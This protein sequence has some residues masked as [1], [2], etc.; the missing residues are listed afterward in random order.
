M[1]TSL[2]TCNSG[3]GR[4]RIAFAEGMRAIADSFRSSVDHVERL[5]KNGI[6]EFET[7]LPTFLRGFGLLSFRCNDL[8][9]NSNSVKRCREILSAVISERDQRSQ[10]VDFDCRDLSKHHPDCWNSRR[11]A[12]VCQRLRNVPLYRTKHAVNNANAC[13]HS[14]CANTCGSEFISL[15]SARISGGNMERDNYCATGSNRGRD[16]PEIL[17]RSDRQRDDRPY[18]VHSQESDCDQQPDERQLRDFPRAFHASPVFNFW[19]I[20]A[21]PAEGA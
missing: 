4:R 18:A 6:D 20:V 8:F 10:L 3:F 13:I 11:A 21:R 14:R 1:L 12:T 19:A 17:R 9:S 15:L 7:L 2:T 16:I 5:K